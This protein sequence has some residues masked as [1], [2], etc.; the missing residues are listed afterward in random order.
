M[1]IHVSLPEELEKMVHSQVESGLYGSASEV[2][3]DALRKMFG[4]PSEW[5]VIDIE[6]MPR[7]KALREGKA[8][9]GGEGVEHLAKLRDRTDR[10]DAG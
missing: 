10:E 5:D 4:E 6:V 9:M 1:T 3:R 8:L 7:L 2:V